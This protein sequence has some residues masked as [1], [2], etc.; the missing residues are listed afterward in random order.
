MSQNK[1][2]SEAVIALLGKAREA[3]LHGGYDDLAALAAGLSNHVRMQDP[4]LKGNE[5]SEQLRPL[6]AIADILAQD[7]GYLAAA[8]AAYADAAHFSAACND[9]LNRQAI[10][11]ILDKAEMIADTEERIKSY[12]LASREAPAGSRIE[13]QAKHKSREQR[14]PGYF[15]MR[16]A[17]ELPRQDEEVIEGDLK[18]VLGGEVRGVVRQQAPSGE[19]QYSIIVARGFSRGGL[20]IAGVGQANELLRTRTGD[21][22][23]RI[24]V[25]AAGL[26]QHTRRDIDFLSRLQLSGIYV[27]AIHG[28]TRDESGAVNGYVLS[29][30]VNPDRARYMGIDTH[31]IAPHD[32]KFVIPIETI[33]FHADPA[34]IGKWSW[35][36]AGGGDLRA[37]VPQQEHARTIQSLESYGIKPCA[38]DAGN[39]DNDFIVVASEDK[40]KL[41]NIVRQHT[42]QQRSDNLLKFAEALPAFASS[43]AVAAYK[44]ACGTVSGLRHRKK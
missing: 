14:Y 30:G 22:F 37:R 33:R 11:S 26:P 39:E 18:A 13:A 5:M 34:L 40:G 15:R 36:P 32:G 10:S 29:D 42:L 38:S 43:V 41:N 2:E 20:T 35:M 23:D 16:S 12:R 19:I 25:P 27:D 1:G 3:I 44:D 9:D 28:R 6:I 7:H 31:G 24:V 17:Q 21:D 8:I 4:P